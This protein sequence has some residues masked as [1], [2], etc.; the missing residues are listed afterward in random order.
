[1]PERRKGIRKMSYQRK[2]TIG[3]NLIP[4]LKSITIRSDW[5]ANK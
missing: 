3:L 2:L 1:M 5:N 4:E